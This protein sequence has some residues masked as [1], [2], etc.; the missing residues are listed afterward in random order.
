VVATIHCTHS[1]SLSVVETLL[2]QEKMPLAVHGIRQ[3]ATLT[4]LFRAFGA[5]ECKSKVAFLFSKNMPE[6]RRSGSAQ[7]EETLH[8][9]AEP[10][11]LFIPQRFRKLQVVPGRINYQLLTIKNPKRVKEKVVYHFLSFCPKKH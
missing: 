8:E 3:V 10:V 5:Q 6:N 7:P 1:E 2:A 11:H 4:R 9:G